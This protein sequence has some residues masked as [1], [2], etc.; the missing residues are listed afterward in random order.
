M[1]IDVALGIKNNRDADSYRTLLKV[2]YESAG[3]K[4]EELEKYLENGDEN[5]YTIKVHALKSSARIVGAADDMDCDRG[6][7]SERMR[8]AENE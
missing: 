2:F 7:P 4:A 8:I 5:S 3:E 1:G 6:A